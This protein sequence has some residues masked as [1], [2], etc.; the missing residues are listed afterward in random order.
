MVL[1]EN[2]HKQSASIE[3]DAPRAVIVAG[4][5][6]VIGDLCGRRLCE[7]ARWVSGL[8]MRGSAWYVAASAIAEEKRLMQ[9][10][11]LLSTLLDAEVSRRLVIDFD[12]RFVS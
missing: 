3:M 4:A 2:F 11:L 9:F 6:T 10:P 1:V 5:R 8:S 12:C 7:C